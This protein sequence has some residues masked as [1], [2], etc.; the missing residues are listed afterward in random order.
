M[1]LVNHPPHYK[2]YGFESL[3]LLEK[4]FKK[5]SLNAFYLGNALKYALRSDF[6][7]NKKQDLL[8]CEFFVKKLKDFINENSIYKDSKD[9]KPYFEKIALKNALIAKLV[10]AFVDFALTPN[11]KNYEILRLSLENIIKED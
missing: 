9:F 3:E 11:L 7:G 4:L 8:K 6:K 10:K 5:T 2:A 1:D